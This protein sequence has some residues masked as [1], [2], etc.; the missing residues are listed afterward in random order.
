MGLISD[1][2][3]NSFI[4]AMYLYYLPFCE[5]FISGDKLHRTLTPLFLRPDQRFVWGPDIKIDAAKLTAYYEALPNDIKNSG[6]ATYAHLPPRDGDF[7]IAK[8]F[9]ELR[10]GWRD[11]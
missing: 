1:K 3:S 6:A 11:W 8:I 7:L 5:V 9:D 4:D 2:D 10:P